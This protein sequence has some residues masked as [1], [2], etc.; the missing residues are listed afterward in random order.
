MSVLE[1]AEKEYRRLVD[2]LNQTDIE[3][4]NQGRISPRAA[5]F[6]VVDYKERRRSLLSKKGEIVKALQESK[7]LIKSIKSKTHSNSPDDTLFDQQ[8]VLVHLLRDKMRHMRQ[9]IDDRDRRL[10]AMHEMTKAPIPDIAVPDDFETWR[11]ECYDRG[12][13]G[14]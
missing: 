11:R 12:E 3:L 5:H 14:R 7:V 13:D 4:A 9:L 8:V 1:N 6:Q 2:E 10:A